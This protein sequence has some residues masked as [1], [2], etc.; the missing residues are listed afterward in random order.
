MPTNIGLPE[1]IINFETKLATAIQ[2]SQKG[3]VA[4]ILKDDTGTFDTREYKSIDEIVSAD[5]TADNFDLIQ[6]CFLGNPNKIIAERIDTTA[7][8]YSSALTRLKT[9]KWNWLA[10]PQ[11]TDAEAIVIGTWI[12]G[13]RTNNN[14]SFKAVL[15]NCPSDN[16]GIVNFTTTGIKVGENT[17]TTAEYCVRI[18]GIFAG[19]PFTRSSTYFVLPEVIDITED[20]EPETQVNNGELILI[21]D[22][23]QI[24]IARGVNSFITHTTSKGEPFSKIKI[25]E[26]IDLMHDDIYD[27]F[28]NS[29]VGKV[30]NNYDN[31]C[32]FIAS[33]N[34]YFDGLARD[35]VL[36]INFDNIADIDFASQKLYLESIGI[37][38]TEMDDNQIRQYNT[39]DKVFISSRVKFVDAMESLTFNVY[40]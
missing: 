26:G 21:R 18:S 37:D 20:E 28:N 3:I 35:S 17:Y 22:G 15:P 4:L 36:D 25:I 38:T 29:Y 6:K 27:I 11:A 34:A 8:D 1:I 12:I 5:W 9:K 39:G 31:K 40:M 19:L 24:K 32:L 16:E 10:V 33:I 2:R 7:I 23:E 14:K 13:Q 30:I